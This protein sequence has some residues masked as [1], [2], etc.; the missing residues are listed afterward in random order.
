MQNW[1]CIIYLRLGE[2]ELVGFGSWDLG[3]ERELNNDI[4]TLICLNLF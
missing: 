2:V 4:A 1:D 3:G